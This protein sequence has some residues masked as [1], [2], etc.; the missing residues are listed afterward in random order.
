MD[1]LIP[2]IPIFTRSLM[3]NNGFII[4]HYV[5]GQ[6]ADVFS[7]ELGSDFYIREG[8]VNRIWIKVRGSKA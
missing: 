1:P 4:T 5:P 7:R 8:V 6:L 3:G 2:L